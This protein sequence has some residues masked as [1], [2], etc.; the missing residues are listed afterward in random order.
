MRP[1]FGAWRRPWILPSRFEQE[2][3]RSEPVHL[4]GDIGRCWRVRAADLLSILFLLRRFVCQEWS[5]YLLALVVMVYIAARLR[6]LPITLLCSFLKV[7]RADVLLWQ[8]RLCRLQHAACAR[9]KSNFTDPVVICPFYSTS[10]PRDAVLKK[11]L[12]FHKVC[13]CKCNGQVGMWR[14]ILRTSK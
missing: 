4:N 9:P 11:W 7:S 10:K 2:S 14:P 12:I 5:E 3:K 8:T 13:S 1:I 6:G